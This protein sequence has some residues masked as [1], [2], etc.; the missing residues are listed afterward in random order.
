MPVV[1]RK[2]GFTIIIYPH[3][4]GPPHVHV[5][6]AEG[7]VVIELDTLRVRRNNG[8]RDKAVVRAVAIVA[9]IHDLL[10]E[11]WKEIHD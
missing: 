2:D 11:R 10:I 7:E 6:R 4:H 8:M 1:Y 3:D 5:I 9:G